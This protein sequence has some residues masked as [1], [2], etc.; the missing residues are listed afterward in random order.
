MCFRHFYGTFELYILL[1]MSQ[2]TE[3][4]KKKT[5]LKVTKCI[6]KM[7][8]NY[9]LLNRFKNKKKAKCTFM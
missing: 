6:F 7:L 8:T 9:N 2:T 4:A 3:V 1:I 5:T